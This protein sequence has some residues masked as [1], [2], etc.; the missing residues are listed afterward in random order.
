[1]KPIRVVWGTG[2]GPT[3]LAARDAAFAAANVHQY[4]LS[5]LSSVIPADASIESVGT[6]PDLGPVGGQLDVVA[7]V[8]TAAEGPASAVLVW[9][10]RGDG[11]GVFYESDGT[12]PVESVRD[13]AMT[14]IQSGVDLRE[15]TYGEIETQAAT[16]DATESAFGAA[17]VFAVY[18]SAQS[19]L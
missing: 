7:A 4:N 14:G 9:T 5:L 13:R 19:L 15:G 12:A 6:A 8:A 10:R 3:A 2:T 17:A 1:M 16:I 11:A 18:G